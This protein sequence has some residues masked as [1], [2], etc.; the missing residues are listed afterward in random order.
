MKKASMIFFLPL[1][2]GCNQLEDIPFVDEVEPTLLIAE[3]L[4]LSLDG[5]TDTIRLTFDERIGDET[6][7]GGDFSINGIN[8]I[9]FEFDT[10]GDKSHD[11]I[12]HLTI[13]GGV[14]SV[15]SALDLTYTQGTL[16]D[17]SD[18]LLSGLVITTTPPASP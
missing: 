12:I 14:Y 3:N 17:L 9:D 1:L 6:V 15:N 16:A 7:N 2:I 4:D 10:N 13:D 18:N 8:N 5:F 11:E